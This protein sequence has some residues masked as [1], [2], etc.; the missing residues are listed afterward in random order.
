[1]DERLAFAS[2]QIASYISNKSGLL[3]AAA[4]HMQTWTLYRERH[5]QLFDVCI[6]MP[7]VAICRPIMELK[8][9]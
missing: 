8:A 3:V 2:T 6:S 1:M 4:M 5:V 7:A 9:A